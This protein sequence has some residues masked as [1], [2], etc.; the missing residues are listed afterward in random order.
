MVA[1]EEP[2]TDSYNRKALKAFKALRRISG[3]ER[4]AEFM[5]SLDREVQ[6]RVARLAAGGTLD[7]TRP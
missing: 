6:W 5:L 4:R 7:G 3:L 1:K 2:M